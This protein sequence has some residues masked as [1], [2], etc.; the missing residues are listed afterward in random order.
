M[1]MTKRTIA[2]TVAATSAA[3]I[4]GGCTYH[5]PRTVP[6][7]T[8]PITTM[9]SASP[10]T[11]VVPPSNTPTRVAYPEGARLRDGDEPVLLGVGA[12]RRA[13]ADAAA[14]SAASAFA[15]KAEHGRGL[16]RRADGMLTPMDVL[17]GA[18]QCP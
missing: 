1:K 11:V 7:A 13:S 16:Q 9:P 10:T 6:A 17:K 4:L 2:V 18:F 3:A 8:V 12:E 14:A 5:E 15:L